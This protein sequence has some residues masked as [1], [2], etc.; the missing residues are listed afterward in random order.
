MAA[1]VESGGKAGKTLTAAKKPL[2]PTGHMTQ[3]RIRQLIMAKRHGQ[4]AR[5]PGRS[6]RSDTDTAAAANGHGH[7]KFALARSQVPQSMRGLGIDRSKVCINI[8][9]VASPIAMGRRYIQFSD[10][11]L[12][13]RLALRA[14]VCGGHRHIG[15]RQVSRCSRV[16]PDQGG[17][18]ERLDSA[19]TLIIRAAYS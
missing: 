2:P 1:D 5:R 18:D 19:L 17:L 6:R 10:G 3:I 15:A 7:G 11:V 9:G 13:S 8:R 4:R 16:T 14:S 12:Q